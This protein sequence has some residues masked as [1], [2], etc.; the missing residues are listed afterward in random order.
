MRMS[1]QLQKPLVKRK[2]WEYGCRM[3]RLG[4]KKNNILPLFKNWA[5]GPTNL[6][7]VC[8]GQFSNNTWYSN[9]YWNSVTYED[10]LRQKVAD[11]SNPSTHSNPTQENGKSN[12]FQ[13]LSPPTSSYSITENHVVFLV[14]CDGL[15]FTHLLPVAYLKSPGNP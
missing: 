12:V 13:P 6:K 10:D 15:L 3:R 7:I 2:L 4:L 8:Y 5:T 11:F 14:S 9:N 1:R